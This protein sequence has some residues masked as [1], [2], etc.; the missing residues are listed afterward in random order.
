VLHNAKHF[1]AVLNRCL[2]EL[3]IPANPRERS[4]IFSKML[5]IPKQQAWSLLEG[6]LYPDDNLLHRIANELEMDPSIFKKSA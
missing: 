4:I 3:D 1:A 6:S 5:T 2:D